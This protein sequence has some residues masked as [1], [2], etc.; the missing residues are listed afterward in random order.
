MRWLA[1]SALAFSATAM[2]HGN[3]TGV[4]SV[5][6]E[7]K[8]SAVLKVGAAGAPLAITRLDLA[9]GYVKIPAE[10]LANVSAGKI[11]PLISLDSAPLRS[12]GG[13]YR[14]DLSGKAAAGGRSG[15]LILGVE[16]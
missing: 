2:A 6:A 8:P 3:A 5:S 10:A 14:F 9:R 16:L 13:Q 15:P 12:E 4:L 11:R 1:L 7:V